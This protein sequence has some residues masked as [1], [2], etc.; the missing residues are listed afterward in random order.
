MPDNILPFSLILEGPIEAQSADHGYWTKCSPMLISDTEF[1]LRF[2]TDIGRISIQIRRWDSWA[3]MH[4][5]VVSIR[6]LQAA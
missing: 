4:I 1:H 6:Q 3:L 5:T 2:W